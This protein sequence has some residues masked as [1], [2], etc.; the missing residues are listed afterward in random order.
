MKEKFFH[1]LFSR[2]RYA[3]LICGLFFWGASRLSAQC[4]PDVVGP[5]ILCPADTAVLAPPGQC[6]ATVTWGDVVATDNCGTV[7]ITGSMQSGDV[8][9]AGTT[10]VL[11]TATDP[12][13]NTASC[14]MTVK[15]AGS[16][17]RPV[18]DRW[19]TVPVD[20]SG[21]TTIFPD[22][23][24]EYGPYSC[25]QTGVSPDY[26]DTSVPT[27][28]IS[29]TGTG[30]HEVY[31]AVITE[32]GFWE[33]CWSFVSIVGAGTESCTPD[34]TPPEIQCRPY[35][36]VYAD[37]AQC[38]AVIELDEPVLTDNCGPVVW[39]SDAPPGN[40]FSQDPLRIVTYTATDLAGNSSSCTS[41]V[42]FTYQEIILPVCHPV[43]VMMAPSGTATVYPQ[44]VLAGGPYSCTTPGISLEIAIDAEQLPFLT[45]TQPGVYYAQVFVPNFNNV[46][47]GCQAVITVN[48]FVDACN[49]ESVPPT[50]NCIVSLTAETNT[51][52][53]GIAR[54]YATELDDASTD[55]CT[56]PEGLRFRVT[57]E[58]GT[59]PPAA[60]YVDVSGIVN[61]SPVFL[62]VGDQSD[63]WS[64]CSV[65][66]TT[67][68]AQCSPDVL[69]PLVTPPPDLTFT[70]TAFAALNLDF[71]NVPAEFPDIYAALGVGTHWDNCSNGNSLFSETY[72]IQPDQII[73]S[74]FAQDAA[75]NVSD[76]TI[77]Y[78][79]IVNTFT[80]HIPAW[81]T[82]GETPEVMS[83]E[84]TS[85]E[86]TFSNQVFDSPCSVPAKIE[87]TWGLVDWLFT[88]PNGNAVVLPV[89]D[90]DNDGIAGDAYDIIV[91]GDSV[92]LYEN[93]SA[94]RPLVRRGW[95]YS[96][97]Q[98]IVN[99]YPVTGTVFL[100]T[101]QD[102]TFD[103]SETPLAGWKVKAIGQPSNSPYEALTDVNGQFILQVCP[104]DTTV[105][106]SL[107]VPF[108]Y[109][110]TCS[111][112]YEL[113]VNQTGPQT[114]NIPAQLNADCALL[115]VDLAA[116][117]MRPCFSGYYSV[118]Y[119]NYSTQ[120][121]AG[122]YID[123]LLDP[124]VQFSFSNQPHTLQGANFY[125][126]QTGTLAP[127]AYGQFKIHY[128][129][130]CGAPNGLTHCTEATI[131]PAA[132]CPPQQAWSGAELLV[133]G[134][135][136][137]DSVRLQITNV[138]TGAMAQQLDY[139]VTE[140][141]IMARN[142]PYQLGIGNSMEAVFASE[143]ATWRMETPQE[144]GHPWGGVVSATVEGCDGLNSTGLVNVFTVDDAD[145]FSATDCTQNVSSF[146]P[147]DKQG[148][149][150][151]YGDEHFINRNTDIEYQIR[152]QNTGTDVAYT[153]VVLDTLSQ[154]LNPATVRSGA[155]SHN[156]D[157]DILDGNVLRFRFDNIL[158]PDSNTNEAASHGFVQ[159]RVQ[160]QVDNPL[161]TVIPNAAAIYFDLNEPVITNQ[162]WHTVNE[163]F[164][165][166]SA[167]TNPDNGFGVLKVYPN[168]AVETVFFEL[169]ETQAGR[170]FEMTDA[171][172]K[173]VRSGDFSEKTFR[174]ERGVLPAGVYFF[175]I[176]AARGAAVSGKIVVK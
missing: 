141:L 80:A 97:V 117:Y 15:V 70:A 133:T 46:I 28:S 160:Q 9:P 56:Q 19:V 68:P 24:L 1:L 125:R 132:D 94:V 120:A 89:L 143:G 130:S 5:V 82:P 147:N 157:F 76:E 172:G 58:D 66:L 96:Y 61:D 13:G 55:N 122:T 27:P 139:V 92:W 42:R 8:F 85:T 154:Y 10:T 52:G 168:P 135:C 29:F 44:D 21:I 40:L 167:V 23:I 138:G 173:P 16:I 102:C 36:I 77:Q 152:F 175:R 164:I 140:D 118:N 81:A 115:G 137:G 4:N 78:I 6:S 106:V 116:S 22:D 41:T 176:Y 155:S 153:V 113:Q 100:D 50:A 71:A 32:N 65:S 107:D 165:E 105:E 60:T 79:D 51:Q 64:R 101:Q 54:I 166:V 12:A 47:H 123:V 114:Q 145:P 74:F 18:C 26:S 33:K 109:A 134:Q 112:V 14:Q 84:G 170:R 91:I 69:P 99:S 38:Q 163:N 108:N 156:Y 45:L 86:V 90:T 131:F 43:T 127:G 25:T 67:T 121:V 128:V 59:E 174:L 144:P 83:S 34:V 98:T 37:N 39:S 159:F 87:R 7:S 162:T 119:Y 129:L 35:Y 111:S 48:A 93:N 95:S 72:V 75:G 73:R 57:T 150:T 110:G 20:P 17:P 103:G 151:G 49:P 88:P 3:L 148:L 104:N 2:L 30:T 158:L 142:L 161:G 171:T 126:F 146:D 169:P 124:Y 53:P 31:G 63:N 136:D 11:Y 149:P 62:W